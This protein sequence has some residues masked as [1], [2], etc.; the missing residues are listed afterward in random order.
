MSCLRY[1]VFY[2][3]LPVVVL[4]MFV[5]AIGEDQRPPVTRQADQYGRGTTHV[6][7]R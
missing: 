4:T 2:N 5:S 3:V 6:V 7:F 1:T